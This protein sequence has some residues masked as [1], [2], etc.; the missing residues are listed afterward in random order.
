[1]EKRNFGRF[2]IQFNTKEARHLKVVELLESR[3]RRKAQFIAEA[4]LCYMEGSK[5][6]T[7]DINPVSLKDKVY[8]IVEECLREKA[9]GVDTMPPEAVATPETQPIENT[10][11]IS[12]SDEFDPDLLSAVQE[13]ISSF[14]VE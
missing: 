10:N 14:R 6:E 9:V 5:I 4:V 2:C 11:S 8:A 12:E 3:G 7:S 1:M 13:S